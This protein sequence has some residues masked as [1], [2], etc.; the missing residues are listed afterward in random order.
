M[1]SEKI[2]HEPPILLVIAVALAVA[3][4]VGAVFSRF[5]GFGTGKC[6][7]KTSFQTYAKAINEIEIPESAE[8]IALGEATHGNAEFQKLKLDIFKV[9]AEK[10]G[11][12]A[13]CLE[14]DYGCCEAANRYI[15]GGEGTAQEA[16][17]ATGF[18]IYRTQEM[19]ELLSWMRTWNETAKEGDDLRFYGFDM[20]R[21]EYNYEYLLEAAEQAGLDT[22]ELKA[23]WDEEAREYVKDLDREKKRRVLETIQDQLAKLDE[24]GAEFAKILLENDSVFDLDAG[25]GAKTRDQMMS[26]NVLWILD[27]EASYG[28]SRI[29]LSAHNGHVEQNGSYGPQSKV[30]GNLLA[31]VVG[32]DRYY[33]I[34]TDFYK[35]K[36]N[37]PRRDR[38]RM[39]HTF[40]SYDSM[41]KAA[42]ECGYDQC[43][44]DFASIPQDSPL[45]GSAYKYGWMGSVGE[46]YSVVM[47]VFP[48]TY[49]VWRCPAE[50]YDSMIFVADAHPTTISD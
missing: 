11:I 31:D 42:K 6:A 16:A 43:W 5:G 10:Y 25:S 44:L 7:D 41:A 23:I 12:R 49:R 13:F 45:Y 34:G 37:L 46:G 38:S 2:N 3:L 28:C 18:A 30:M 27:Q 19:A 14:A 8:I 35:A 50:C 1:K 24:K 15:H 20:Q 21:I 39:T 26:E 9:M 22:T 36:V 47:N 29:F 33:A 32:E 40:Y 4:A 48:M 17:A